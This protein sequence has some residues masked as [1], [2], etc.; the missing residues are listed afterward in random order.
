VVPYAARH[1]TSPHWLEMAVDAENPNLAARSAAS[2]LR[3]ACVRLHGKGRVAELPHSYAVRFSGTIENGADLKID[4][5][6]G[7]TVQYG[8]AGEQAP[9]FPAFTPQMFGV[10]P[11]EPT[12]EQAER[13]RI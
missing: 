12:L 9:S 6:F 5:M 1:L 7:S 3:V 10:P 2:A 4:K 11:G 13:P 8:A